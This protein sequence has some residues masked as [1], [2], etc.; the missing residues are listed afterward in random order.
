MKDIGYELAFKPDYLLG[1][2][3]Q[4]E[5]DRKIFTS[6]NMVMGL[7]KICRDGE[8]LMSER[9]RMCLMCPVNKLAVWGEVEL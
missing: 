8:R 6:M 4:S 1:A 9:I 3:I 7:Q 5:E 2:S